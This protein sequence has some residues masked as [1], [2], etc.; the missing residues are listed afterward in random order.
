LSADAYLLRR[1]RLSRA[2]ADRTAQQ[3][4]RLY[5]TVRAS[6]VELAT[7]VGMATVGVSPPAPWASAAQLERWAADVRTW[8]DA[9]IRITADHVDRSSE[10]GGVLLSTFTDWP[11]FEEVAV[12]SAGA[13]SRRLVGEALT[14]LPRMR[15]Y[16]EARAAA[17]KCPDHK[18]WAAAVESW[19]GLWQ[20][21]DEL[22]SSGDVAAGG[23]DTWPELFSDPDFM[24]VR[25]R[26]TSIELAAA[27]LTKLAGLAEFLMADA[28]VA[29]MIRAS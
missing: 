19:L 11:R 2:R 15:D 14:V 18:G 23:C 6:I 29:S 22:Q 24:E 28:R 5:E 25:I 8:R 12:V 9:W 26:I 27:T 3:T 20:R 1:A 13:A 17:T 10:R 4:E 16:L 7:T 21:V